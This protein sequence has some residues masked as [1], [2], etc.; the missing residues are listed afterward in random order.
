MTTMLTF[1]TRPSALARWQTDHVIALLKSAWPELRF[2]VKI[3]ITKGDQVI[4][5]PLPEIGGKGLFTHE[6]EEAL[7][8]GR[9]D[10]AVHS[11]K[12]LPTEEPK[13]LLVGAIPKRGDPREVWICPEGLSLKSIPKEAVVG[14]SSTRRRAQLLASRPDLI[15]KPIRGN[16]DTRLR[17][18]RNG[19]Y[20]AIVLAAAGIM[21]LG[22]VAQITEY[23]ALDVMLPAP[24]QGALG[25]QCREDDTFTQDILK[26]IE[27]VQIRKMVTAERV[28]LE[29]LGGGCSL[30]VGALATIAGQTIDLRGVVVS[31][32]GGQRIELRTRGTDPL[33]VGSTLAENALANGAAALL[34]SES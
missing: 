13:G 34:E 28:F 15:V 5:K 1:A 18:V 10:A 7:C 4:D 23:I 30:P 6:L 24:A 27:D 22:L 20:D 25:V 19:E 3:I 14:T 2:E 32:L 9:V 21:R 29:R 33:R 26:A 17:K 12:D 16:V 31:P 8:T 11:M